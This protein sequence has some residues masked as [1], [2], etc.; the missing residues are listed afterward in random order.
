MLEER[1]G[2]AWLMLRIPAQKRKDRRFWS[3]AL[4]RP[5]G[6]PVSVLCDVIG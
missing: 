1:H 4:I 2:S 3:N 6:L 5:P